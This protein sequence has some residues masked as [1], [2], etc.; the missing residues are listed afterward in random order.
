[1][2]VIV[3]KERA[4]GGKARGSGAY[5]A[6]RV[7]QVYTTINLNG[8]PRGGLSQGAY[9]CEDFFLKLLAAF[10]GIDTQEKDAIDLLPLALSP[11]GRGTVRGI[12]EKFERLNWCIRVER[13]SDLDAVGFDVSDCF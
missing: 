11:A 3:A 2:R 9:F 5:N 10:S 6:F 4:C 13:K 1:M 12:E 7:L 8:K